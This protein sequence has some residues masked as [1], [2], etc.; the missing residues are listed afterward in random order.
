M[1]P[2]LRND[3]TGLDVAHGSRTPVRAV[4]YAYTLLV[5]SV[6][7]VAILVAR[8]SQ[9]PAAGAVLLLA[10]PMALV[11]NRFVFF[12]NETGF[13]ADA[14]VL[15]AAILL[16]R[17]DAVLLGPLALALLVGPL[18]A[19]HWEERAFVR[20]AF[21]SGNQG[22]V[23]LAALAAFVPVR[24]ALG[25]SWVDCLGAAAVAAVVYVVVEAALAVGL[26]S[27]LGEPVR[28]ATRQQIPLHLL[29][30]PLA[31]YGA[32]AGLC[33]TTFGWWC[34][35][36]LLLPV[37]LVPESVLVALPRRFRGF[38]VRALGARA[39][40]CALLAVLALVL[41]LPD[42][43][44]LVALVAIAV[45]LGFE[46]RVSAR[47][48]VPVLTT[49]AVV[50]G[51]VVVP[52]DARYLAAAAGA[53]VVTTVAWTCTRDAPRPWV[54]PFAIVVAVLAAA[55][56]GVLGD[57]SSSGFGLVALLAIAAA[58]VLVTERTPS[59]VAWCLPVLAATIA[60]AVLWQHAAEWGALAFSG[61]LACTLVASAAWGAPVWRSRVL[62]PWA[63]RTLDRAPVWWL[64]AVCGMVVVA[65]VPAAPGWWFVAVSG[66]E[67]V[68]VM[69]IAGVRQWRFAPRS[70]ARGCIL[71][72]A[73]AVVVLTAAAGTGR[74][75][76]I[77]A[78]VVVSV[79]LSAWVGATAVRTR[80]RP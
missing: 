10:V 12:P 25:S 79:A 15:F 46:S 38:S 6:V 31:L 74:S 26:V 66:A 1:S 68:V 24:E 59:V 7:G 47:R 40:P 30:L 8:G 44:T 34:A 45:G 19:R 33:A 69:A 64:T 2:T 42:P 9:L 50:A 20:M 52:G 73:A 80:A 17:D 23:T 18:D 41:P 61:G 27:L 54:A 78:G 60:F 75:P 57:A 51:V 53:F 76:V 56:R 62:G 65:M 49:V 13:T 4:V 72:D 16:F 58:V 70:R 37:P 43:V 36:V 3:A 71:L 28:S 32:I 14:A 22:T 77:T 5:A 63:S 21:N 29:A 48:P 55:L 39:V 11:I 67:V 35:L